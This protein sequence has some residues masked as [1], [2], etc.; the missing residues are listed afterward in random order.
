V[1]DRNVA[2]A[3]PPTHAPPP[4]GAA[5][6]FFL[7]ERRTSSLRRRSRPCLNRDADGYHILTLIPVLVTAIQ[8]PCVCAVN[9]SMMSLSRRRAW[10][11]WIPVTSTGMRKGEMTVQ[12]RNVAYAVPPPHA[13]PYSRAAG[14]FFLQERRASSLRRRSALPRWGRGRIPHPPPHSCPCDRNPATARLR[15]E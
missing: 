7:Q 9:D 11:R 12:D 3:V 15:G 1:Q 14:A 13:P 6:A 2:Y 5:G 10:A 4:H 8:P